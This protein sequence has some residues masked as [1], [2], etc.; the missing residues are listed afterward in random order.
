MPVVR[1]PI[2]VRSAPHPANLRRWRL[3]DSSV[4][5]VSEGG[6]GTPGHIL[7]GC[8][9]LRGMYALRHNQ[10]L[11]V[12]KKWLLRAI[13]C[14][15][16]EQNGEEVDLGFR[17]KPPGRA[18]SDDVDDE[19]CPRTLMFVKAKHRQEEQASD[20]DERW[21]SS[22]RARVIAQTTASAFADRGP[23][24]SLLDPVGEWQLVCDLEQ[25]LVFPAKIVTATLRTDIVIC[26]LPLKSRVLIELTVPLETNMDVAHE[27]K[28][29][30][31]EELVAQCRE[32][33]MAM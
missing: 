1:P 5:T 3:R 31:Y 33:R 21:P 13:G 2:D 6:Q 29:R 28:L 11:A 9:A 27:R 8:S 18:A 10:V 20:D 22:G 19:R 23:S 25:Q 15:E 14:E 17:T 26:S 7:A 30:R 32:K 12:L 16:T 24:A 4:C